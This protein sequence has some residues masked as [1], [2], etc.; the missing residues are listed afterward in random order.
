MADKFEDVRQNVLNFRDKRDWSRFH[1]PK[2]LAEAISIESGELL[3]NFLWMTT[4]ESK[5]LDSKKRESIGQEVAD[6]FIYLTYLCD[7][8]NID[9]LEETTKKLKINEKRFPDQVGLLA[10]HDT[11]E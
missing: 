9:L 1:D 8:L 3:E 6:I 2:D 4:A 10:E 11:K 7:R 5:S